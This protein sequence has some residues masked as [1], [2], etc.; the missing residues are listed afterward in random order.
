MENKISSTLLKAAGAITLTLSILT[1]NFTIDGNLNLVSIDG[2]SVSY[3]PQ[4]TNFI[5]DCVVTDTSKADIKIM[6][7]CGFTSD[8]EDHVTAIVNSNRAL[9]AKHGLMDFTM[10]ASVKASNQKQAG[11]RYVDDIDYSKSNLT[12]YQI[13][14]TK[15][16]I[17]TNIT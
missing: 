14:A 3:K 13:Q 5:N 11:S 8:I 2:L 12:H 6:N 1:V 9:R 7:G 10:S 4:I 17:G 15:G 16:L